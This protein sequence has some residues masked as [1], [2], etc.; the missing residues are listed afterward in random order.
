MKK[1][2]LLL[3]LTVLLLAGCS[4]KKNSSEVSCYFPSTEYRYNSPDG[5]IAHEIRSNEGISSSTEVMNLYLKGPMDETLHNLFPNDLAVL[6]VY[7]T[8]DS[9]Y[10]TVS[11]SLAVLSGARLILCCACLGR[12]AMDLTGTSS[13]QIRCESLLLDGKQSITINEKTVFYS[14]TFHQANPEVP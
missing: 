12:T 10:V 4:P 2:I 3:F 14:D 5:S 11:D 6:A 1:R 7:T 13:A 9:V 8:E